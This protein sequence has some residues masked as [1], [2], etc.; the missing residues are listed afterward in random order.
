MEAGIVLSVKE[1]A[2]M[3][4]YQLIS[5]G[6]KDVQEGRVYDFDSVFD[7]LEKGFSENG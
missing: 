7:E 2:D 4:I 3:E 5:A 6:V 1:R